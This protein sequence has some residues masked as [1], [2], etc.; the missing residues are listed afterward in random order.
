MHLRL[1]C[2]ACGSP[3]RPSLTYPAAVVLWCGAV[4]CSAVLAYGAQAQALFAGAGVVSAT[5]DA[6]SSGA[7]LVAAGS[8]LFRVTMAVP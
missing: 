2:Q 6:T 4:Q 3:L 1:V 7:M 5:A 8:G